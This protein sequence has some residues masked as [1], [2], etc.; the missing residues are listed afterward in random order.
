MLNGK[1]LL[2]LKKASFST[3]LKPVI[4]STRQPYFLVSYYSFVSAVNNLFYFF[5][6]FIGLLSSLFLSDF[7]SEV[8]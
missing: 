3:Q 4:H 7:T 2:R 6:S 5:F 8:Y 1:Y